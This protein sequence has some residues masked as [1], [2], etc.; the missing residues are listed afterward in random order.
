MILLQ[1]MKSQN[2][3]SEKQNQESVQFFVN[4]L[5]NLGVD[6]DKIGVEKT[7]ELVN[8]TAVTWLKFVDVAME[9]TASS[10]I[11]EH[12]EKFKSSGYNAKIGQQYP[13]LD[14]A[15]QAFTIKFIENLI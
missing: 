1:Y 5:G 14:L 4:L 9:K 12:W 6:F 8:Q 7:A 15:I 11:N 2:S 10:D 3:V 13:D